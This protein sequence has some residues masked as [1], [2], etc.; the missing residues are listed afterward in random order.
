MNTRYFNPLFHREYRLFMIMSRP[1]R[2]IRKLQKSEIIFM[3]NPALSFLP[4]HFPTCGF[5]QLDF[6]RYEPFPN[7][8]SSFFSDRT[9][10]R[11]PFSFHTA[12]RYAPLFYMSFPFW[13]SFAK[14]PYHFYFP[15]FTGVLSAF[16]LNYSLFLFRSALKQ[17]NGICMLY[18]SF[19][20]CFSNI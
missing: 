10:C 2:N 20:L 4:P 14:F 13:E 9:D 6:V 19:S 1:L 11:P 18:C 16:P 7:R 15:H 8:P 12:I 5:R 3:L 17:P